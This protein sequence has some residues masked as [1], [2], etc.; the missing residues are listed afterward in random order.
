MNELALPAPEWLEVANQYL[1]AGSA[2]EAADQ[3]NIPVHQVTEV[4]ARKDV[5][6]Y[7][8]QIY[9]DLGYRNRNKLGAAL[10]KIIDAKFQEAEESGLYSSKDLAD[11]LM[12]A[13]KMRMDEIK[14]EK[15]NAPL[16]QTNVQVNG[17]NYN[18]LLEKLLVGK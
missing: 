13:H 12:M 1:T 17:D 9:M 6:M 14:A 5:R 2:K 18:N 15:D 3:L 16:N 11:L 4:L 8:N 10:D 7:L